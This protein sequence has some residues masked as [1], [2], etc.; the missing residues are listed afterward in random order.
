MINTPIGRCE[1]NIVAADLP[2]KGR[3]RTV[4]EKSFDFV[5]AIDTEKGEIHFYH[6]SS[7]DKKS[8]TYFAAACKVDPMHEEF[9]SKL[10][11]AIIKFRESHPEVVLEKASIVLSDNTVVTDTVNLPLINKRALDSSLDASLANLYGLNNL[12]FNRAL[13]AQNK[14]F[15]TYAVAGMRKD[16][17]MKLQQSFATHNVEVTNVTFA[18]AAATNAAIVLNPKLKNASFVLM[19]I[20]GDTT[21]IALAVSGKTLGFYTLPFGT[22]LLGSDTCIPEDML[23]DHPSAELLVLNANEKAKAKALTR[24]DDFLSLPIEEEDDMAE[25]APQ[26][27][28]VNADNA[29][30]LDE[31]DDEDDTVED[32]APKQTV[33]TG[34]LRKKTPRQLPKFMQREIPTDREGILSENFRVFVKWT[35]ELIASNASI[36]ALGAPEAVYVNMPQAYHSLY[37][38]VN[39]EAE[40]NGIRFLPLSNETD[41]ILTENL[42][43][44]GGFFT[45]M[46]NKLNNFHASQMDSIK[47]KL[48]SSHTRKDE[49]DGEKKPFSE[50]M[51]DI[52]E[53]IKKI[54]N[55]EIGGKR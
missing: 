24:A 47:E 13:A 51:H 37:E 17:L 42:E 16:L 3:K 52:W 21:K 31:D 18:S 36:T 29:S 50:R 54:A 38:R 45:P 19:D 27:A 26:V 40:E 39:A 1:K 34:K 9:D 32:K 28:T 7:G 23:F 6:A 15:A 25:D 12:R 35:L 48:S 41:A 53:W 5:I 55:T 20:Q 14:Q 33:L 43:L 10:A 2:Q 44:Y 4:R 49:K 8:I 11:D 46:F 30:D 22:N